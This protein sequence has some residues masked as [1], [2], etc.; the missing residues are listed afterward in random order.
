MGF[1]GSST[2]WFLTTYLMLSPPFIYFLNKLVLHSSQTRV[3]WIHFSLLWLLAFLCFSWM[4]PSLSRLHIEILPILWGSPQISISPWRLSWCH[5]QCM[6]SRYAFQKKK[7]R[8]PSLGCDL[9]CLHVHL[10]YWTSTSQPVIITASMMTT[11]FCLQYLVSLTPK[12]GE[13]KS[14][15]WN[16]LLGHKY[17]FKI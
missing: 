6:I 14:N 12:N 7:S 1:L 16:F 13:I 3:P 17:I 8:K 2:I 10:N 5:W 4:F 15:F 11:L 9:A